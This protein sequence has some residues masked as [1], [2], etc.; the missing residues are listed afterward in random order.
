MRKQA[1]PLPLSAIRVQTLQKNHH[2]DCEVCQ[3]YFKIATLA[4]MME[5]SEKTIRIKT[6][7]FQALMGVICCTGDWFRHTWSPVTAS[8]FYSCGPVMN[9]KTQLT[10]QIAALPLALGSGGHPRFGLF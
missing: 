8:S 7:P 4:D 1:I 10:N 5:V 6:L 3:R 9:E 2:F